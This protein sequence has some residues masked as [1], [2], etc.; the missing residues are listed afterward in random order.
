LKFAI[1]GHQ[2]NAR[3]DIKR[4]ISE[5]GGFVMEEIRTVNYVILPVTIDRK[6]SQDTGFAKVVT[7][8]WVVSP[9]ISVETI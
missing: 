7:P 1:R 8:I 3:D 2:P 6:F 9:S 4:I 5:L